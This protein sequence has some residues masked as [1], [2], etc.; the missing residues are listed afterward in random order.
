MRQNTEIS[1]REKTRLL[2]KER[3]SNLFCKVFKLKI[4]KSHLSQKTEKHLH[5]LFLEVKWFYNYAL[6]LD[7][8]KKLNTKLLAVPVKVKDKTEIRN[9]LTISSQMKQGIRDRI[10]SNLKSLSSHKKNGNKVGKLKFKSRLHSVPLNQLN[11]TFSINFDNHY[12]KIQ[13]LKAKLKVRGLDQISSLKEYEIANATLV[14]RINDYYLY[15]T[16]YVTKEIKA[17]KLFSVG[18]DFGCNTQ[19]T[20]SNGIKIEYQVPISPKIKRLDRKIMKGN[21]HKK[22][23]THNL[24]KDQVKREKAYSKLNNK[25]QDIKNKIV[26]ILKNN[27]EVVCF[28]NESIKGW[29][30]GNHGKKIQ[31]TAIGGII[32]ILK[33]RIHTPV[34]VNKFFPSTQLCPQCGIKNKLELSD[35]IYECSCGY[36]NDR[37]IK[38]AIM[39]EKEGLKQLQ[40]NSK[41]LTERK[42]FKPQE[43]K[44]ST[45]Y[46]LNLFKQVKNIS[47]SLQQ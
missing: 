29:Q 6:S 43:Q 44:T 28:Q 11:N 34:I 31:N 35:R 5:N 10:W 16:C 32:S 40:E 41:I 20:L 21:R 13:G 14:K 27:Y 25:K 9:I 37:D 47:A 7:D 33:N 12:I 39:I 3:R 42:E 17:P 23:R 1:K 30:A 45:E 24:I 2:T 38:S 15:V 26:S 8:L 22:I 4:D 19:L 36:K 18:I 46:I